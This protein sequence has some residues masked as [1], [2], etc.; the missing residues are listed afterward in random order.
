MDINTEVEELKSYEPLDNEPF[1]YVAFYKYIDCNSWGTI[2]NYPMTDKQSL[3][4]TIS[5]MKGVDQARIY[6][7]RLPIK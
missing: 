5:G 2:S 1:H 6:K 3:I 7:T 4:N